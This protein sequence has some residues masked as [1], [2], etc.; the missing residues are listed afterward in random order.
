[1][2]SSPHHHRDR[3]NEP[4]CGKSS[5]ISYLDSEYGPSIS[6][7]SG[8]RTG[9]VG[10]NFKE[11]AL[12]QPCYESGSDVTGK[13][14]NQK[15]EFYLKHGYAAHH[16]ANSDS[17]ILLKQNFASGSSNGVTRSWKNSDEEEYM[18]DEINTR[19]T[20]PGAA[21]ISAKD[22][23]THDN[24]ER[25]VSFCISRGLLNTK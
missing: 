23:S 18:W 13:L 2:Q 5:S 10:E 19:P 8:L 7:L 6:G 4:V 11:Q 3:V 22:N 16:S 20:D 1:M 14:C 17:H 21:H 25:L 12:D 15:N 24:Y 9:R